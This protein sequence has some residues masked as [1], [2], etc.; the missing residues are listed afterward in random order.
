VREFWLLNKEHLT[1]LHKY[2]VDWQ[3][4]ILSEHFGANN[5]ILRRMVQ[6][7]SVQNFVRFSGTPCTCRSCTI[8]EN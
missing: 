7:L 2:C 5:A 3:T 4:T 1:N 6:N 8:H